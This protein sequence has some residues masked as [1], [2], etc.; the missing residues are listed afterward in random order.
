MFVMLQLCKKDT[1]HGRNQEVQHSLNVRDTILI[2]KLDFDLS[3][4]ELFSQEILLVN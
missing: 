1:K 4:F 3:F 2:N